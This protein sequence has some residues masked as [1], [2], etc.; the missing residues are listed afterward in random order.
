M[1]PQFPKFKELQLLDAEDVQ[2]YT[3]RHAPFSDFNFASLWLWNVDTSVQLSELRQNL[4]VRFSDYVTGG[5]FYSLLGD[6]DLN[7][8]VQ[9]LINLSGREG[10]QPWLRLVPEVVAT[11][12]DNDIFLITED[13][14]HSDYILMVNR[15]CAYEGGQ[16]ASKRNEVRKFLRACPHPQ[17]RI[18][19]LSDLTVV[20]QSKALFR[21]WNDQRSGSRDREAEREYRAFE[22][23]LS[24]HD[25]LQLIGTGLF[26]RDALIG[27]SIL[28]IVNHKYA[29]AHF[30]K[31]DLVNFPGIGSFLNQKVASLLAA[32]GILYI[33]I[34]ED[35]GIVGLR[36]NKRSYIPC[37]YLKKFD[38]RYRE[39][40]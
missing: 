31:T 34:E 22:R 5:V 30:E 9:E 37:D 39:A 28:E 19:D 26:V 32:R 21:R 11:Q 35:L 8:A 18:L 12:L 23:C 14:G 29:F 13:K 4:V 7:A 17:F 24:S 6:H 25:H 1:L 40:A 15:L 33:N 20:G 16:F 36:M 2:Q 27:M 10:L 38:V 3:S